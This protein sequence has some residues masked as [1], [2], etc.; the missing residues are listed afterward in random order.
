VRLI[1]AV[2]CPLAASRGS[3]CL[4]TWTM[5]G[6]TVRCGIISSCQLAAT[7]EIVK[8][9]LTT[10][11]SHV[12]SAIASTGFYLLPFLLY[13][14]N[15]CALTIVCT[16]VPVVKL[17]LINA[18]HWNIQYVVYG[19][20]LPNIT[21]YKDGSLLVQNDVI[22]DRVTSRGNAVIKGGLIF[23]MANHFNNGNYTL[24]ASNSYGNSSQTVSAIFLQ[25]PGII[26]PY[27]ITVSIIKRSKKFFP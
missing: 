8:A 11:S 26:Q 14:Y 2:V 19:H 5:D 7:S 12:R 25:S 15:N 13:M 21:W 18:F 16:A 4:L 20:P 24:V 27:R 6:R 9:L 1:G 23:K 17:E 22:Y 10:S 3:N